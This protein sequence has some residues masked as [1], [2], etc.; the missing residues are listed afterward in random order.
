MPTERRLVPPQSP[1]TRAPTM[2]PRPPRAV[3]TLSWKGVPVAS[4]IG[5]IST[6]ATANR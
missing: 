4:T 3:T 2:A 5:V 1:M 6:V